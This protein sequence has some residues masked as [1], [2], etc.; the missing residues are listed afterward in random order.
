MKFN[1]GDKVKV[2]KSLYGGQYKTGH[3][4]T[5]LQVNDEDYN[6][7]P[8]TFQNCYTDEE[9]EKVKPV[10]RPKKI[11]LVKEKIGFEYWEINKVD[12]GYLVK[13]SFKTFIFKTK[14]QMWKG[15][16]KWTK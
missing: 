8:E 9:L 11:K 2:R 14:K 15:L 1:V 4:G 10:G 6:V 3:I 5:I 16:D 7:G 13:N 12:N